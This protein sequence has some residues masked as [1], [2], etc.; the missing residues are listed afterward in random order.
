MEKTP[1]EICK[2]FKGYF[3]DIQDTLRGL[4]GDPARVGEPERFAWPPD[5]R[6][7]AYSAL[8]SLSRAELV[9]QTSFKELH[10]ALGLGTLNW[11]GPCGH[12]CRKGAEDK[13]EG[14]RNER[15]R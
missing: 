11:D 9:V 10:D 5:V 13:N 1:A 2:E 4:Y 7:A 6:N 12:E 14:I 15:I 3:K 8:C